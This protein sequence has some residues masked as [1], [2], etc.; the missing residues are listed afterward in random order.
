MLVNRPTRF[1]T[2]FNLAIENMKR[3]K[4]VQ[5][6]LARSKRKNKNIMRVFVAFFDFKNS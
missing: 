6:G 1:M 4:Y 2:L 5:D 3:F